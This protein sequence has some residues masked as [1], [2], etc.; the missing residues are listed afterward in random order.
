MGGLFQCDCSHTWEG[1]DCTDMKHVISCTG[2]N[3]NSE[4][5]INNISCVFS[6]RNII[7]LFVVVKHEHSLKKKLSP[8]LKHCVLVF[9]EV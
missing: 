9:G 6:H 2:N 8:Y 3:G 5:N 4:E 1:K 7:D